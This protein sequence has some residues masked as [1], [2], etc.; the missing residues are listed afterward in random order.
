M[1]PTTTNAQPQSPSFPSLELEEFRQ[2]LLCKLRDVEASIASLEQAVMLDAGNGTDDTYRGSNV[3]E[4]GQ[5]TLEREEAAYL[6]ARQR[7]FRAE[8][9]RALERVAQGT[10]GLC[11]VTGR[12][13]PAER[14]RAVPTTTLS[15]EAK[16]NC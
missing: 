7:K 8:L 5:A 6:V 2:L 10:Y 1:L 12:R 15:I 16:L 9:V 11:L 14:L 4:D 3:A 13:I